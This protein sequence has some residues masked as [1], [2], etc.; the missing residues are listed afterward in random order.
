M[1]ELDYPFDSELL[2][3]RK[4]Q[5]KKELLALD[6]FYISKKIA[7]LGGQTTQNIKLIMELF[8]L[9]NGIKAEF[10]ESEYN[11]FYESGMFSNI[12][13]EEFKPDLI[14]IKI[15]LNIPV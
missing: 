10:Y 3:K 13:L 8:L 12:E 1:R 2:L 14:A 5:I 6:R 7:I 4:K 11:Q 9:N 15:F